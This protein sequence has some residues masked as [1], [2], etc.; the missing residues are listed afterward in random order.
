MR[1]TRSTHRCTR[2]ARDFSGK[3]GREPSDEELAEA[4]GL[5]V[6]KLRRVREAARQ[7]D[8]VSTETPRGFS[9]KVGGAEHGFGRPSPRAKG[10]A[11]PFLLDTGKGLEPCHA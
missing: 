9:Q 2:A 7:G 10:K 11:A 3:H 4:A 5:S 8:A 1:L 6:D